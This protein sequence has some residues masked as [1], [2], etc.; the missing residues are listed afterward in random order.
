[1][2][3]EVGTSNYGVALAG[4]GTTTVV[5]AAANISGLIIHRARV[6]APAGQASIVGIGPGLY[7]RCES[8]MPAQALDPVVVPPGMAVTWTRIGAST[9]NC[10]INYELL[11]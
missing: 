1:M 9:H 2:M 4:A 10:D 8:G 6:S 5:S 7:I 11:P 3:H